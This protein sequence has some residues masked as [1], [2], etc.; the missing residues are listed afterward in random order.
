MKDL[1]KVA[2]ENPSDI[3]VLVGT[4]NQEGLLSDCLNSIINQ[5]T[6]KA[7]YKIFVIDDA[8][9]DRTRE[10]ISK[11]V[12]EYPKLIVPVLHATN[13]FSQGKSP[14]TPFLNEID[15]EFIA[16]CDGDD[17]WLDDNKLELQY[18]EFQRNLSVNLVHTNYLIGRPDG[19]T[20]KFENRT[21][22][23]IFRARSVN[24]A[25]DL[26]KGNEIKRSTVMLRK[27]SLQKQFLM[28]AM[29]IQAQDWLVAISAGLDGQ[30]IFLDEPMV[31]YRLSP[32]ASYQVLNQDLKNKLKDDVRWYCASNLPE[33]KTRD[34]FRSYLLREHLRKIIRE[35]KSY[36]IIR[37]LVLKYR[38]YARK[39]YGS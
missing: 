26:V 9:T 30:F 10:V 18:S 36:R 8:S 34:S 21:S 31:V 28:N 32:N 35:S 20:L 13:Q 24:N 19:T 37:P 6:K 12:S 1:A 16:F 17:F 3:A 4:Y 14:E 29:D 39:I 5:K 38:R 22:K 15:A 7:T 2:K 25:E 27:S 23:E 33:G 11:F